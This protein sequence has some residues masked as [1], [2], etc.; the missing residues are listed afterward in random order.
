[1]TSPIADFVVSLGSDG[2]IISQGT[3][4][5]ALA[6][7][8]ALAKKLKAKEAELH[9]VDE[10]VDG[11]VP[12]VPKAKSGKLMVAEEVAEGH[13]SW[14]AC[15]SSPP[16]CET[17]LTDYSKT[18]LYRNGWFL[19]TV[20][21]VHG[22]FQLGTDG[23]LTCRPNLVLG[24]VLIVRSFIPMLTAA[25]VS[26]PLNTMTTTLPKSLPS[27]TS[28]CTVSCSPVLPCYTLWRPRSSP[29]DP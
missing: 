8:K 25:Q 24:Y 13:V 19:P 28:L 15:E 12:E 9:K 1:M 5:K 20:L 16:S 2:R 4:S 23:G 7:S 18:I 27:N 6:A 26:G 10:T 29:L 22:R 3:M 21:L 11:E 14:S 17:S